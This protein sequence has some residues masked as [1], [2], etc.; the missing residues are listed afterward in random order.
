MKDDSIEKILSALESGH[1]L[2]VL[3]PVAMKLVELATDD[4]SSARDL[5]DL[6]E[7]DPPL[8]AR[9]LKLANSAFYQSPNPTS[10]LNQAVVKVGFERLRVMAL[11]ISLRDTFPMG[12]IGPL[13][14]ER[15]WRMS[16]YR[17]AISRSLA[18]H[19]GYDHADEAFVAGLL[20]ELGLLLF[21]EIFIKG[22]NEQVPLDLEPVQDLLEW[23]RR[24]FGVDHR[25][26][27]QAALKYW[28]F[29]PSLIA[30]QE[31]K[32]ADAGG[33][34]DLRGICELAMG[35]AQLLFQNT[36]GFQEIFHQAE[37]KLGL[38]Q[39][40]VN[41]IL[42]QAFEEVDKTAAQFNLESKKERDLLSL[43]EKANLAL[44]RISER[45]AEGSCSHVT[46]PLPTLDS[47]PKEEPGNQFTLQAIAHE[48][49][50]PLT[51]VGGF[52]RRLANVLDPN[53]Q[54]GKYA[55]LILNDANRLEKVLSDMTNAP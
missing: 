37:Q 1:G 27:G 33:S 3:S 38:G 16:L 52:A 47:V 15:F 34:P 9:L 32:A 50:N 5:V 11:S 22:K 53:S 6:I 42:V 24:S 10:S 55:H 39:D 20:M 14:Y 17:A 7:K 30:C 40:T 19:L 13:D 4:A 21:F 2:P 49:R 54:G 25:E 35:L 29:A 48:I 46:G 12:K 18:L 41:E 26:V 31:K 45:I 36:S 44:S 43:M 51:A 8:A 28:K 23:E